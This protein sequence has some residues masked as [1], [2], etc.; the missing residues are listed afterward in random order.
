MDPKIQKIKEVMEKEL[1]CS[2]HNMDHIMRVYN[3]CMTLAKG[4]KVDMEV[5]QASALLHDLGVIKEMNDSS[6]NTDHAVVGAEMAAPILKRIGFSD[7]KI[8]HIQDCIISHRYK[9]DNRPKTREA[10]I[11]FDADKIDAVG[12]IGVA[13]V[14]SWVGRN[15]AH[16]YRKVNIE[17]YSKE[18]LTGGKINGRIIDKTKHSPQIDYEIKGKFLVDMLHTP[19]AKKMA[20]ER[21]E[22]FKNFLDRLEKEVHGEL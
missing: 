21:A 15:D 17:E 2:A 9:T 3:L 4:D 18:N 11:V 5:I 8:K 16:I 14:Y 1:S 22:Y 7:E 10:E 19:Q 6:G 20:K 12:A 13:R